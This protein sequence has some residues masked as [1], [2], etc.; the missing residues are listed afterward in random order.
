M[1]HGSLN[2]GTIQIRSGR[3]YARGTTIDLVILPEDVEIL[4]SKWNPAWG[5]PLEAHGNVKIITCEMVAAV[6]VKELVA[7]YGK[8]VVGRIL[9]VAQTNAVV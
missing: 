7:V 8:S 2:K 3:T 5:E 1:L 4:Y 9:P 6:P